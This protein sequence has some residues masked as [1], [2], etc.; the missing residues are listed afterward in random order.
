MTTFRQ[1]TVWTADRPDDKTR[2]DAARSLAAGNNP[3]RDTVRRQGGSE[4]PS[5]PNAGTFG[6]SSRLLQAGLFLGFHLRDLHELFLTVPQSGLAVAAVRHVTRHVIFA[7]WTL[8]LR[9]HILIPL[10]VC[11]L[12]RLSTR[13]VRI[14]RL[15]WCAPFD[16]QWLTGPPLRQCCAGTTGEPRRHCS[17][18]IGSRT[19]SPGESRRLSSA[20]HAVR[21]LAATCV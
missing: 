18:C 12:G 21:W 16:W 9:P 15:L 17:T 5:L 19:A 10:F 6:G 20:L 4:N 13:L 7:V 2:I 1:T 14:R 3:I 11:L 8:A